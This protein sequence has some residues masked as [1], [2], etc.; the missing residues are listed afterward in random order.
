MFLLLVFYTELNYDNIFL[1]QMSLNLESSLYLIFNEL[2][3]D[4]WK[5][6]SEARDECR[7]R[8]FDLVTINSA[9]EDRFLRLN[10]GS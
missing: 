6:W 1:G 9:K 10:L 8:G 5:T 3:V 7:E 4:E 2:P